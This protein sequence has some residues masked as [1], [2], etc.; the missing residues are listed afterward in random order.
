VAPEEAGST[1]PVEAGPVAPEERFAEYCALH[2]SADEAVTRL[3][4]RLH[5]EIVGGETGNADAGVG[6]AGADD[7]AA[8]SPFTAATV[9]IPVG[10]GGSPDATVEVAEVTGA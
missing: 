5:A 3:F 10:R 2:G 4:T 9:E 8:E 7:A 6:D 1:A